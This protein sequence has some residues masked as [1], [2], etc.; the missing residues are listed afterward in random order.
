MNLGTL[1]PK[2]VQP[3]ANHV[4]ERYTHREQRVVCVCGWQGSSACVP[5]GRSDWT[6]H[7]LEA[8]ATES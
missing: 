4:I 1:R 2:P 5:G 7:V 6:R 8:K 3:R